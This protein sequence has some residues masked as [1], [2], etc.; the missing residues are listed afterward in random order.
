[1]D[2]VSF[3]AFEDIAPSAQ[4]I[5]LQVKAQLTSTF[6]SADIHHVGSTAIPGALTKGDIDLVIRVPEE[7][8]D[9]AV[10]SLKG[11]YK[12]NQPNNWTRSFASFKDD[13]HFAL[14]ID[15]QLVTINAME[16]PFLIHRDKLRDDRDLLDAYN[17]LKRTFEGKDMS[18]YR[19]AKRAF[20][21]KLNKSPI[22]LL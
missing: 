9:N 21:E 1:M 4:K 2:S 14:P 12:I 10:Q 17:E 15:I 22:T 8:F 19:K 6:P 5:F 11:S 20:F 18:E 13:K 3:I 16:D 7:I